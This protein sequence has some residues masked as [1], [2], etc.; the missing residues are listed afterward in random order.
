[1]IEILN[2]FNFIICTNKCIYI[3]YFFLYSYLLIIWTLIFFQGGILSKPKMGDFDIGLVT[4]KL[5]GQ[6][7]NMKTPEVLNPTAI[8]INWEVS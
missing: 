5:R 7:V 2:N 6:V 8:K 4:E 3:I 1:M